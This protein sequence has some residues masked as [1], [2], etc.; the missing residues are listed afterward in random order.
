MKLADILEKKNMSV[1]FCA[2]DSGIAY[3][4]L[5][6][7]VKG[8][9]QIEMCR[10]DMVRRLSRTLGM[11][12]EELMDEIGDDS[13]FR[14][15]SREIENE[16]K[17]KGEVRFILDLIESDAIP[18]NWSGGYRKEAKYLLGILDELSEKNNLPKCEAYDYLRQK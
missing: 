9:K 4:T 12:M 16:L 13:E 8:I 15:F 11:T 17:E 5:S 3:S 18:E 10:A 2:K 1:Y 14:E 6:D 7:L